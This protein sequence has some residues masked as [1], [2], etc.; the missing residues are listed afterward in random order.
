MDLQHQVWLLLL[1]KWLHLA[2]MTTVPKYV[3]DVATG[4]GIWAHDFGK[5][6]LRNYPKPFGLNITNYT[7]EKYPSSFVIGTDLSA[8]QPEP[9][10]SNLLFQKDD[11]EAPWKFP[12]HHPAGEK[13][14]SPCEHRI[15][16]DYVHLRAVVTCFDDHLTVMQH[17]F[18]N[19][20]PGAWIEFQDA[21][22]HV[23]NDGT[24]EGMDVSFR[25]SA[26]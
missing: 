6:T 22:F 23:E 9:R 15:M 26:V 13:C 20:N 5:C 7:A 18:D 24:S 19:M 21:S 12:A 11:A 14:M 3:L 25:F 17:A 1:D 10:V 16:F 4:T 2:P 8:I